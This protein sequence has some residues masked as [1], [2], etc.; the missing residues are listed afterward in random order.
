MVEEFLNRTEFSD[1]EDFAE[2][3][4]IN[5]PENF[6]FAYDVA[7][8]WAET[9]PDKQALIWIDA[10]GSE[11]KFTFG[12]IKEYSDRLANVLTDLGIGRDD[13]VA[14]ILKRRWEFWP[15]I[16][17]CHKIGARALPINHLMMKKDLV[18]RFNSIEIKC[19][20]AVD[21]PEFVEEMEKAC[22]ECKYLKTKILTGEKRDGWLNWDNLIEN[23][24]SVWLR[25]FV[26][27]NSDIM[28]MYFTSGTTG[29]PKI[30]AHNYLYPL[31]HIITA[32]YFHEDTE[33]G[34][35]WTIADTGWAKASY[36]KLYG[37]WL[38]GTCVFVYD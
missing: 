16:I 28:L 23:A 31:A 4:K 27:N 24:S 22:S 5:I 13:T 3:F 8:R 37:Q 20:I 38:C 25:P 36:G 7:D 1:Y 21:R 26:N 2:N 34:I 29:F 18:Y 10:D 32:K 14:L 6:N 33:N 15:S 19:L 12:D 9:E 30:V 35:D 11:K 17:A